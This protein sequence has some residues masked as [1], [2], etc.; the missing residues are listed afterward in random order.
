MKLHSAYYTGILEEF[1]REVD[2]V[3]LK[4]QTLHNVFRGFD[5]KIIALS[6]APSGITPATMDDFYK[7]TDNPKVQ[8]RLAEMMAAI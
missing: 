8:K 6:I 5:P 7:E 1:C 4:M 3:A 2:R